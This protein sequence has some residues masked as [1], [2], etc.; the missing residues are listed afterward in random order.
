MFLTLLHP[1]NNDCIGK[2]KKRRK[3]EKYAEIGEPHC[4]WL[5]GDLLLHSDH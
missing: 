5:L 4:P 2:L 1:V 3:R